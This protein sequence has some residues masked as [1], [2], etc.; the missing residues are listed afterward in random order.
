VSRYTEDHMDKDFELKHDP[1]YQTAHLR[2]RI[3]QSLK[4][5]HDEVDE[6]KAPQAKTL[7]KQGAPM[8]FKDNK[9]E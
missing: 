3:H 2:D 7:P 4:P 5:I 1:H 9:G 8:R 6:T